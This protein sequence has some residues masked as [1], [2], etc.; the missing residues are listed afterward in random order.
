LSDDPA[1]A[2]VLPTPMLE[3][4]LRSWELVFS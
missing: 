1:D 2:A 4:L 3:R